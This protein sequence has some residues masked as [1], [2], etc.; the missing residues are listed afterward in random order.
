MLKRRFHARPL[1]R[2]SCI[3]RGPGSILVD[4][5]TELSDGSGMASF[6]VHPAIRCDYACNAID[7]R[8]RHQDSGDPGAGARPRRGAGAGRGGRICGTDRHLFKGEFPCKPP[9]TL[10]HEFSGIVVG[11]VRGSRY[12]RARASYAIPMTGAA[13]ATHA[14]AGASIYASATS[15]PA[16]IATAALPSMPSSLRERRCRFLP[17]SIR[18]TA[19]SASRS[20]VRCTGSTSGRPWPANASLSLAAA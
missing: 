1:S 14:C 3:D 20:P 9:V 6:P 10:G 7:G 19:R 17:T 15:P 13:A 2:C 16:S 18:C 5:A 4:S 8:R 11:V 12:L